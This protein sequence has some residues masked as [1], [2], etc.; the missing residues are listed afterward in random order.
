MKELKFKTLMKDGEFA[1][2]FALPGYQ[3]PEICTI[4]R[5]QILGETVTIETL[6]LLYKNSA[7][8]VSQF[9]ADLEKCELVDITVIVHEKSDEK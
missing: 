6:K 4:T 8:D 1:T 2:I 5:P 3:D 9:F 7:E